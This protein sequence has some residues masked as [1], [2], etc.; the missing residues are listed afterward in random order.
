MIEGRDQIKLEEF[1]AEKGTTWKF[2]TPTAPH[3]NGCVE[4]LVKS[5]KRAL[6]LAIG[7][8]RSSSLRVCWSQKIH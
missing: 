2:T 3:D 5:A 7:E 8:P 6:K 1:G 4:S